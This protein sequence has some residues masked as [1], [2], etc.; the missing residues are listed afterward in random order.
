MLKFNIVHFL[1]FIYEYI[2]MDCEDTTLNF[3]VFNL[4]T[5]NVNWYYLIQ[6]YAA[7]DFGI[8]YNLLH[9]CLIGVRLRE[10]SKL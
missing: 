3:I 1:R 8:V 4:F 10:I 9:I 7:V 2:Y 6:R 5:R